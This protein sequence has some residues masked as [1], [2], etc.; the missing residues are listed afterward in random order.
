MLLPTI[1]E[2]FPLS[3]PFCK[4]SKQSRETL[5]SSGGIIGLAPSESLKQIS[6]PSLIQQLHDAKIIEEEVFSITL[7]NSFEGILSVG[8]TAAESMAR[9]SERIEQFLGTSSPSASAEQVMDAE[10]DAADLTNGASENLVAAGQVEKRDADPQSHEQVQDTNAQSKNRKKVARQEPDLL[11]DPVG[12]RARRP[13]PVDTH[14]QPSWKDEWRWTPVEG[15]EGWWQTL[16]RGV[17][18]D[19]AKILKNQPCVVDVSSCCTFLL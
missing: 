9:I 4:P 8:G 5:L 12:R 10:Q 16:M 13:K 19:N 15:A 6:V 3:F 14:A 18:V 7:I 1:H 2:Q 11:V 17:W